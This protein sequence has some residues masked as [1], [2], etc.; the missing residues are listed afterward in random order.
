[1]HLVFAP[2]QRL[3]EWLR[4]HSIDIAPAKEDVAKTTDDTVLGSRAS[5]ILTSVF[6]RGAKHVAVLSA[7]SAP[8]YF[9]NAFGEE[10]CGFAADL[11]ARDSAWWL[12]SS[13]SQKSST[14]V[15]GSSVSEPSLVGSHRIVVQ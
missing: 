15:T 12:I 4:G 9:A 2:E 1:M 14:M 6:D 5:T 8:K 7:F 11:L 3:H 10:L 13:L